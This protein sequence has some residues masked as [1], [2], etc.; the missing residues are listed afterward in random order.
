MFLLSNEDAKQFIEFRRKSRRWFVYF[1]F[2]SNASQ[3]WWWLF[4]EFKK[5]FSDKNIGFPLPPLLLL[6]FW[7]VFSAEKIV[8]CFGNWRKMRFYLKN[9][10]NKKY[11]LTLRKSVEVV[12]GLKRIRFFILLKQPKESKQYEWLEQKNI[13]LLWRTQ[14]KIG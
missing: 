8:L 5:I 13:F 2:L 14:K 1:V 11:F 9:Q 3:M 4:V 10:K 7:R 12:V 6:Q